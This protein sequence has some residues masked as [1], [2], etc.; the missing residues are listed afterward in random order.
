MW[1]FCLPRGNVTSLWCQWTENSTCAT[2]EKFGMHLIAGF[3]TLMS[4][5]KEID[6]ELLVNFNLLNQQVLN[7]FDLIN[8]HLNFMG[9]INIIKFRTP[10]HCHLIPLGLFQGITWGFMQNSR[11]PCNFFLTVLRGRNC[12]LPSLRVVLCC[13]P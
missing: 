13:G 3:Y 11:L 5:C 2:Q 8:A 4:R 7:I 1:N 9:S 12:C 6:H 10:I